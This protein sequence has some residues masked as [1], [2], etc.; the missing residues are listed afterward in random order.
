MFYYYIVWY[1]AK[2][3]NASLHFPFR[4]PRILHFNF[5]FLLWPPAN[6]EFWTSVS[7]FSD[8]HCSIQI[9]C[10]ENSRGSLLC[11]HSTPSSSLHHHSQSLSHPTCSPLKTRTEAKAN[12]C[13]KRS[14]EVVVQA[15]I[16]D[17]KC[18]SCDS[19][20]IQEQK[21]FFMQLV[22]SPMRIVS[23]RTI[24]TTMIKKI[25]YLE[26]CKLFHVNILSQIIRIRSRGNS[27][28]PRRLRN[29]ITD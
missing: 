29:R 23:F 10:H 24:L 20:M 1:F 7:P 15:T 14:I 25:K 26:W 12:P 13:K 3:N 18:D 17:S 2:T 6:L 11:Q 19:N 21:Q 16:A 22:S 28:R 27:S 5:S 8:G 9:H 4:K